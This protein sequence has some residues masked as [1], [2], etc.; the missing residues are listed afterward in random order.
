MGIEVREVRVEDYAAQVADLIRAN[1]AETGFDFE[2]DP[3]FARYQS[4]Q[5]AGALLALAAFDGDI[6]VGYSTAYLAPHMFNPAV[7]CCLSEALFV[8]DS[9]RKGSAPYR[10]IHATE[11]LA[12]A[13]GARRMVWNTRAGT[14]FAEMLKRRGYTP[15]EVVVM[16]GIGNG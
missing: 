8:Q 9:Y 2:A 13:R 4:I 14:P 7:V 11:Q 1:W 3:D 16:K 15:A 5:D 12:E 6:V 10:L